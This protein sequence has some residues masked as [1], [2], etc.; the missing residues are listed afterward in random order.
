MYEDNVPVLENN[1]AFSRGIDNP[2]SYSA[3]IY[4]DEKDPGLVNQNYPSFPFYEYEYPLKDDNQNVDFPLYSEGQQVEFVNP[5][6]LK[7]PSINERDPTAS[8]NTI[9]NTKIDVNSYGTLEDKSYP[10]YTYQPNYGVL[11]PIPNKPFLEQQDGFR[12]Y[13]SPDGQGRQN[14]PSM[15][16]N[17]QVYPMPQAPV[18]KRIDF[19]VKETVRDNTKYNP[20]YTLPDY[21]EVP[22]YDYTESPEYPVRPDY[23]IPDYVVPPQENDCGCTPCDW[24]DECC[25]NNCI[26]DC[27]KGISIIFLTKGRFITL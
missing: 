9:D 16:Y 3:P 20:E 1:A 8:Y 13:F 22:I 25:F 19:P 18:P 27:D 7:Y 26:Q 4:P 23:S 24:Y 10:S 15:Q 12:N 6:V 5:S 17:N 2:I 11:P 14:A 21:N